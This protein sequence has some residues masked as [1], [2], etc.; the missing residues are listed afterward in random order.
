[1]KSWKTNN[2]NKCSNWICCK[3]KS[4][5]C[6]LIMS[7]ST[8][9]LDTCKVIRYSWKYLLYYSPNFVCIIRS[10]S[11]FHW[12]FSQ[13][14]I[15]ENFC[16]FAKVCILFLSCFFIFSRA[17]KKYKIRLFVVCKV[18]TNIVFALKRVEKGLTKGQLISEWLFWCLQFSKKK[19]RKYLMNFCPRIKKVVKSDN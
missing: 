2:Q 14:S 8:R 4:R 13:G 7:N 5:I 15:T 1:M 18:G 19:P 10:K 3:V 9:K 17:K 6:K 16:N 11:R 12:F